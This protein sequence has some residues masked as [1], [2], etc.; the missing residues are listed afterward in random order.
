M[1]D[2][3][4]RFKSKNLISMMSRNAQ[5]KRA[6]ERW[7]DHRDVHEFDVVLCLEERVFDLVVDGKLRSVHS[8]PPW[9]TEGCCFDVVRLIAPPL[10]PCV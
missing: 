7:Q 10:P 2:G 4:R 9:L 1:V 8:R 6:P 5:L 3:Y